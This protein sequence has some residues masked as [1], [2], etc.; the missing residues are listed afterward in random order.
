MA[1]L[2]VAQD[3]GSGGP[4]KRH[5]R[6]YTIKKFAFLIDQFLSPLMLFRDCSV[7]DMKHSVEYPH[8]HTP[9]FD[10]PEKL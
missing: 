3:G 9:N 2:I 4:V 10:G 1:L 5:C 8:F 7:Q 6:K